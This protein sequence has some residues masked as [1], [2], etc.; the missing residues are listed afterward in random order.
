M[1]AAARPGHQR[2]RRRQRLDEDAEHRLLSSDS[3]G[4]TAYG[5]STDAVDAYLI[6]ATLPPTGKV[7]T[8]NLQPF[9][10]DDEALD[11]NAVR[12][13]VLRQQLTGEALVRR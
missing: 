9:V 2:R 12:Q 3:F 11:D 8:G 6:R 1:L 4:H 10:T 7:C 5:T 13:Q